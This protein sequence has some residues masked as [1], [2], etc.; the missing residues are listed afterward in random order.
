MECLGW[1]NC[2][3]CV[4]QRKSI[5]FTLLL[6]SIFLSIFFGQIY[7]DH[8]TTK[9]ISSH[10][11]QPTE[12]NL[13][14][15]LLTCA[16]YFSFYSLVFYLVFSFS[17]VVALLFKDN[18]ETYNRTRTAYDNNNNWELNTHKNS[19]LLLRLPDKIILTTCWIHR[20]YMLESNGDDDDDDD[21][22]CRTLW[23]SPSCSIHASRYRLMYP[24]Y[25]Y[26]YT[27]S[28][29]KVGTSGVR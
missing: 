9:P 3:L 15:F 4:T 13:N 23:G 21:A 7:L 19:A 1:C 10:E 11:M 25:A 16:V 22:C 29:A 17:S 28:V 27:S 24:L 26:Y 14:I 20:R 6:S 2:A 18:D 5:K 12:R 8:Q